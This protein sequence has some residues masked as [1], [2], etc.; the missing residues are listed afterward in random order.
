MDESIKYE[1]NYR[2]IT[3]K[4]SDGSI[5]TGKVNICTY[6]RLSDMIK[7]SPEK[8]MTII[9]EHEDGSRVAKIINKEHIVWAEEEEN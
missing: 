7:N 9:N 2:N 3:V 8:F 6:A 5:V 4:A 1:I